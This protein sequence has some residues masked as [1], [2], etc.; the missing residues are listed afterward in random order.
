M[1]SPFAGIFGCDVSRAG[2]DGLRGAL[3]AG[4]DSPTDGFATTAGDALGGASGAAFV[5]AV[6]GLAGDG[7]GTD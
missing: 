7:C 3:G 4:C 1:N 2:A 5:G 6:D